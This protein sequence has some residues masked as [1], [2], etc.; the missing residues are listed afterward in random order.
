[1][2]IYQNNTFL[3]LKNNNYSNISRVIIS[4]LTYKHYAVMGKEY[5]THS[6]VL[7]CKWLES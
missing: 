3:S 6:F 1:M 5:I 2:S 7:S 4:R